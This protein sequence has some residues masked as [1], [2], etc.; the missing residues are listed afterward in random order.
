MPDYKKQHYVPQSY[1]RAWLDSDI[2]NN[3]EPYV[4]AA[5]KDGFNL[6]NKSPKNILFQNDM[7]TF[8]SEGG[9]RKLNIEKFLSRVESKFSQV[10]KK[11]ENKSTITSEDRLM[12]SLFAMTMF[13]RT[14]SKGDQIR[15]QWGKALNMGLEM[16]KAMKSMAPEDRAKL[17]S[18]PSSPHSESFTMEEVEDIIRNPFKSTL[19][20]GIIELTQ[21]LNEIPFLILETND[22]IGFITSDNPCVWFDPGSF[23]VPRTL[24][25]G[26]LISPELEI[27][28]PISPRQMIFYGRKLQSDKVFLPI[29]NDYLDQLNE[30]TRMFAKETIVI[31]KNVLKA[32]WFKLRKNQSIKGWA[33]ILNK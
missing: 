28:L 11:I 7:Y 17:A 2:P 21:M 16:E 10:R 20:S 15:D 26:G 23:T 4:W 12:L 14:P 13:S 24:G 32:N 31:N 22:P 29:D 25:S 9:D 3:Y 6:H 33:Q 30:R 19:N 1:L 5:S 27:T 8:T 18:I